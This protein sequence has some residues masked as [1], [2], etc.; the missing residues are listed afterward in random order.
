LTP[1]DG[2]DTI[3]DDEGYDLAD[4]DA[5]RRLALAALTELIRDNGLGSDRQP[6]SCSVRNAQETQLFSATLILK[7]RW[8]LPTSG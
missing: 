1:S 8:A 7:G 2:N 4:N 3:I 5:A 6:F